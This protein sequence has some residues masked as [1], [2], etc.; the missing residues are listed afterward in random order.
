[1]EKRRCANFFGNGVHGRA[2]KFR[3]QNLSPVLASNKVL[4]LYLHRIF[5]SFVIF[6]YRS[7]L[8]QLYTSSRNGCYSPE[9]TEEI[10]VKLKKINAPIITNEV[11][12]LYFSCSIIV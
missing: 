9:Y 2:S 1:M 5:R 7:V 4:E 11:H 10:L 6:I 8:D 12:D 3:I